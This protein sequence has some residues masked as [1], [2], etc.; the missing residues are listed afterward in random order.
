MN[1]NPYAKVIDI[2]TTLSDDNWKPIVVAIAKAKPS[3]F[4]TACEKVGVKLT[5]RPAHKY[6]NEPWFDKVIEELSNNRKIHAIKEVRHIANIGLAEAKGI[7]DEMQKNMG[8]Y[9]E[10][11]R[12]QANHP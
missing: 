5:D 1:R 3:I 7:V 9:I 4:L 11:I 10:A 8:D 2:I 6:A 12:V